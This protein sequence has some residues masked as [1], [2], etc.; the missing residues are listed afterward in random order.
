MHDLVKMKLTIMSI[1][2]PPEHKSW[3]MYS[4]GLSE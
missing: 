1:L 3:P 2:K 4:S